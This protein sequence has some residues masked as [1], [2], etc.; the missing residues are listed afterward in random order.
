MS[1][2]TA[3]ERDEFFRERFGATGKQPFKEERKSS[4]G[5]FGMTGTA[6]Y[7]S[8][9]LAALPPMRLKPTVA[10]MERR[11]AAIEALLAETDRLIARGSSVKGFPRWTSDPTPAGIVRRS[12]LAS[13]FPLRLAL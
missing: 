3:A 12:G 5:Y 6:E 1:E 7:R 13:S 2:L 8:A 10:A 9:T 11:Q 4:G